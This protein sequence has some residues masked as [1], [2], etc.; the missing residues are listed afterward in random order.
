MLISPRNT[1]DNIHAE[2]N[3]VSVVSKRAILYAEGGRGKIVRQCTSILLYFYGIFWIKIVVIDPLCNFISR[4]R[5][6]W[7]QKACFNYLLNKIAANR[8]PLVKPLSYGQRAFSYIAPV[9][10]NSLSQDMR[11]CKS[12]TTFKSKLKTFLFKR[13][14]N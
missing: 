1:C 11:S 14:F 8:L 5:V 10:W 4:N 9:L 6:F 12:L 3:C 13:V 2:A 7:A